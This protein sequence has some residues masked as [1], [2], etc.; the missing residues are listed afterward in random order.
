[1]TCKQAPEL[2]VGKWMNTPEPIT[3]EQLRGKVVLI[4][5]FQMLCPGCVSHGLPQ[6]MRVAANFRREDVV[7]LGLHTVFEHHEAQGSRA[8][9]EAFL[10][11]YRIPF[12]VAIDRQSEGGR[13]PL[14]MQAF[15]MQGTPSQ[16]LIDREGRIRKNKFGQEDDMRLGAEIMALL[17]QASP[18]RRNATGISGAQKAGNCTEQA[19]SVGEDLAN[20]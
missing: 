8:A 18:V 11:E 14:T 6:A 5:A 16:I 1:M 7:V 17:D 20:Q 13:L 15:Q 19:C 9:L 4:E 3:L 12:P 2:Q 10:H